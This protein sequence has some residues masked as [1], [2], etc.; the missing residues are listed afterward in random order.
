MGSQSACR[1]ILPQFTSGG[2]KLPGCKVQ[3]FEGAFT[4][5]AEIEI[6]T[7]K[8]NPAGDV[9]FRLFKTLHWPVKLEHYPSDA[10]GGSEAALVEIFIP[11]K[12][13]DLDTG[14]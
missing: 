11:E 9:F 2:E 3:Y 6:L 4:D 1:Q 12:P 10:D 8:K 13:S 7:S 5:D 14:R